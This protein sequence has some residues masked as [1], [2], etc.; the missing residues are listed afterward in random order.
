MDEHFKLREFLLANNVAI[1]TPEDDAM[2]EKFDK[3]LHELYCKM[4]ILFPQ[5]RITP[6]SRPD[7]ISCRIV[8]T[9]SITNGIYTTP[10]ESAS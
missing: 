3:E 10:R 1:N 5:L 8:P 7:S 2:V 9:G 6:Y 4:V